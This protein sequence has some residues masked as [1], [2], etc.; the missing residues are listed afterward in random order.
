MNWTTYHVAQS[1]RG[2]LTNWTAKDWRKNAKWITHNDGTPHTAASLK[3]A[4]LDELAKGHEVI[5][6]GECDN[7]DFK[8]GCRGHPS[9]KP[10]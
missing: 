5:P 1:V 6:C 7:F 10:A 9:T 4:F 8:T 3:Q 2:A